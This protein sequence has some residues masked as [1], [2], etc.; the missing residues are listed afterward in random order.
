MQKSSNLSKLFFE[1]RI[2]PQKTLLFPKSGP[3]GYPT[4]AEKIEKTKND[5]NVTLRFR[6]RL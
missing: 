3:K 5:T 6:E 2:N 4:L 1:A